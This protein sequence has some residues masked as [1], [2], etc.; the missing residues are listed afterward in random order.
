MTPKQLILSELK[1]K[2]PLEWTAGLQIPTTIGQEFWNASNGAVASTTLGYQYTIQT[3]TLIRAEVIEQVFYE[4]PFAQYVSVI[5]GEAAWME[6]IKTNLV[7]KI[8]GSFEQGIVSTG[9]NQQAFAKMDIGTT[10]VTQNVALWAKSYEYNT[11]EVNKALALNNWDI[12]RGKMEAVKTD[13]DLGLQQHTFLGLAQD[14]TD[15]P[16][17]MSQTSVN[18]NTTTITKNISTFTNSGGDFQTFVSLVMA[19]Y[20]S[21]SNNTRLPTHFEIPMDDYLG[22]AVFVNPAYPL[23]GSMLIDCLENAFKKICGPNFTIYGCLYGKM[24]VNAGFW[25][26]NGTQRYVLYRKDPKSLR[27]DLPMDFI[28]AAPVPVGPVTF[29]GLGYGQFTGVVAFRPAEILYFDH[30]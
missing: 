29:E 17:L 26:T 4:I 3:T 23:A 11:F 15:F 13:W 22:L 24:T 1:N 16:G 10:P 5:P 8:G 7:Y 27:M 28:L 14:L 6:T 12:V 9:A 19:N 25:A 18:I 2:A 21:N 30:T 20:F